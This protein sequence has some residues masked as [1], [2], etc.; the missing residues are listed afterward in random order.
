M[1]APDHLASQ[2]FL[3][4]WTLEEHLRSWNISNTEHTTKLLWGGVDG[5]HI[6]KLLS[7]KRK[8]GGIFANA[9]LLV[10]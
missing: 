10:G 7:C 9:D 4:Q 6:K 5:G 3:K 1:A 2:G 8:L